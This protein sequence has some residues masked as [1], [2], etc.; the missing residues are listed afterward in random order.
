MMLTN[1]PG[2]YAVMFDGVEKLGA[3]KKDKRIII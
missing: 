3:L 2:I 1:A